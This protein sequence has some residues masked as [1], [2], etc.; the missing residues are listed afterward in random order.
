MVLV[1]LGT[2]KHQSYYEKAIGPDIHSWPDIC[3][4]ENV[5]TLNY[6]VNFTFLN[7]SRKEL[8]IECQLW[9]LIRGHRTLTFHFLDETQE[10]FSGI[11]LAGNFMKT[12]RIVLSLEQTFYKCSFFLFPRTQKP[13][14]P[15]L[16]ISTSWLVCCI[17]HLI[18]DKK[19]SPNLS[20]K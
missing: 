4:V 11:W 3:S 16:G 2:L 6:V 19:Q 15:I 20:G 17:N 1:I 5:A 9:K 10:V 13:S 14:V 18:C 12:P 7:G 8:I